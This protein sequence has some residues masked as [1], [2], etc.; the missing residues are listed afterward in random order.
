LPRACCL[1]PAPGATGSLL[2]VRGGMGAQATPGTR[3][4]STIGSWGRSKQ[5]L[6][7]ACGLLLITAV[8]CTSPGERARYIE[9]AETL[10]RENQRLE[11]S[12]ADRDDTIAALTRQV[13]EL[14]GFGPDRPADLF[15]PVKLEILSR[16]GGADYKSPPGNDGVTVYLRLRDAD[17]DVVKAPGRIT[18][19]ILDNSDLGNPKLLGVYVLHQ[20]DQL[21]KAWYGRF[22]TQHYTVQCPFP[23]E[24]LPQSPRKVDVKAEF[25]DYLTGASLTAVKEVAI[26]RPTGR[27]APLK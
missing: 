7:R 8:S 9:R 17:G 13:D 11:R 24:A 27:P 20:P 6:L 25:V 23:A 3:Q 2:P 1:H 21:R 26:A 19:Q 4:M 14:K 12:V 18:I 5:S 16:S 10:Q 15:A 22:S